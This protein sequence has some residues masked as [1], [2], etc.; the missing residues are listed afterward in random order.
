MNQ[1]VVGFIQKPYDLDEL[2]QVCADALKQHAPA[3][4]CL[5]GSQA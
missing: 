4:A 3:E 5:S 2:A 1:G